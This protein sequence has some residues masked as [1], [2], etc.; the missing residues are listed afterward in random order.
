MSDN[1][2]K[3][4]TVSAATIT[5]M[6]CI[7]RLIDHTTTSKNLLDDSKGTYYSSKQGNIFYTK[8]GKGTPVVLIHD[9]HP[10]S[11]GAEW[12]QLVKK[13]RHDHTVYT[14]DLLGCGRSD[15]PWITY[16]NY[17]Y[18]QTLNEFI[19]NVIQKPTDVVATGFSGTFA[20]MAKA[21][22]NNFIKKVILVN[23]VSLS[24]CKEQPNVIKK[25]FKSIL[26]FPIIGTSLYNFL[27][28]RTNIHIMFAEKYYY[29][30]SLIS[31]K[32]E[33]V[34][35]E[36]AHKSKSAGK[37]LLASIKGS[38]LYADISK[39]ICNLEN[40]Y[41]ISSREEKENLSITKEYLKQNK[42]IEIT[43]ISNS[44]YLPQQEVPE[45]FYEAIS[46]FLNS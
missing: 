26:E 39:A 45:K 9:F 31:S 27:M 11:S 7:N 20:I 2:K 24:S 22:E 21:F 15:K 12:D 33:N 38:Y 46:M 13:L 19:K 28:N 14:L 34:Y 8:Y 36:S 40:I 16:T 43:H 32:L 5:G 10:A 4:L 18:V 37:Y 30:S 42:N 35:V 29:H 23:P 25:A 3:I 1:F 17:L 41:I 6:Y 44:R